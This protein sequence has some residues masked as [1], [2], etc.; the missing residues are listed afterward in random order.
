MC[1]R[2]SVIFIDFTFKFKKGVFIYFF[3]GT[4]QMGEI[5]LKT[6]STIKITNCIFFFIWEDRVKSSLKR[7]SIRHLNSV[8]GASPLP[9]SQI[10]A[11]V[12]TKD[13]LFLSYCRWLS[14]RGQQGDGGGYLQLVSTGVRE[15]S[16]SSDYPYNSQLLQLVCLDWWLW[17]WFGNVAKGAGNWGSPPELFDMGSSPKEMKTECLLLL[18][19]VDVEYWS[20]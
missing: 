10:P 15:N 20:D 9:I 16:A 1:C 11:L 6:V 14:R 19:E 8:T 12:L 17:S 18:N 3:S 2:V 5:Q 13:R 7:D 4:L